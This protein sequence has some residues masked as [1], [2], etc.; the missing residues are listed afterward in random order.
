[1]NI[2]L[3]IV[4]FAAVLLG[5]G[6][7]GGEEKNVAATKNTVNAEQ[8]HEE[9]N[10]THLTMDQLAAVGITIGTLEE[11]NLTATIRAN[12]LLRVPNNNRATATA[13]YGGVVKALSVELGDYVNKGQVIATLVH[14]QFIQL[15]EE[16]LTICSN[17]VL[18]E[19]EMQRQQELNDGNAGAKRNLQTATA[20]LNGL[21]T[22]KASLAQQLRL[23]G[24]AADQLSNG[25]LRSE[26]TIAAPISGVI[27]NMFAKIGSFIDVSSPVVEIVDN[28][29]L[30][31]D[32]QVFEKDLPQIKI[33]QTVNFA[34]TNNPG[35]SYTAKVF[36]IGS[37]FENES[38]TIAVHCN[39]TG[40][41]SGLIDGMNITGM[42]S[43]NN[44]TA[45][46]VPDQAIVE[47]D[48]KYYLFVETGRDENKTIHF[49]KIEVIKGVSDVGYTS[50]VPVTE[51]AAG[52]RIVTK[53]AFFINSKMTAPEEHAH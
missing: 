6:C 9:E 28:K 43:L 18:A 33:G 15:Q 29:L 4:F 2:V 45:P 7:A 48:G 41:K 52:T 38:K 21:R 26:L 44:V 17:I 40:D 30:H 39:V 8:E 19:Q 46:A 27:S 11:K 14:P 12:G 10:T 3:K 35:T 53:G 36:N 31:L 1:M 34:L 16:Y 42:I 51:I 23:M 25:N 47:A 49:K 20:E 13:L 32:L 22:R 50:V 24:I 37:S 5:I